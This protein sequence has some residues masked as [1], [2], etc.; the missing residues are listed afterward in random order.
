MEQ[1]LQFLS[2]I[3]LVVAAL[4]PIANPFST[5]PMFLSLTQDFS[6][7]ERQKAVNLAT[8]YMF[9]L[10]SVFLIFGVQ[11]LA[12][13]GIELT[14]LRIAGGLIIG[15]LGFR[16]LFPAPISMPGGLTQ[17]T[18][19]NDIAFMPLAMPSM[20][21]PGAISVVIAMAARINTAETLQD[22]LYGY[23]VVI[24]GI[25]V[26]ALICWIVLSAATKVVKFMGVNGIIAM[27]KVMGF[28]LISIGV[29]M[30][31][32]TIRSFF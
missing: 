19:A 31:V 18:T 6:K 17:Q 9:L 16:M 20:S 29:D 11:L 14:S 3:L 23:I 15:Y 2:Y 32:N 28:F 30:V 7:Q 8:L 1:V 4:I 24:A 27:T 21:G 22:E 10:L 26:A 13:F 25:A 5:A 12:F